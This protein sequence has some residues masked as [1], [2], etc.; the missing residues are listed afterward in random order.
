MYEP[1]AWLPES[2]ARG[3][4][5]PEW[6][7]ICAS[8]HVVLARRL[9]YPHRGDL[10]SSTHCPG[11][12]ARVLSWLHDHGRPHPQHT[13]L[14]N[15]GC[16]PEIKNRFSTRPGLGFTNSM[17]VS[18]WQGL[19]RVQLMAAKQEPGEGEGRGPTYYLCPSTL[20]A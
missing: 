9:S 13:G 2:E 20:R 16:R 17:T 5:I 1:Q 11:Q 18:S 7:P 4:P 8:R 10:G 6:E 15:Q 14:R 3:S 12:A 19:D